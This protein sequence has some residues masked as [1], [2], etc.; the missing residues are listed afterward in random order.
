MVVS[1]LFQFRVDPGH[2]LQHEQLQ[3]K[4][5]LEAE[6]GNVYYASQGEENNIPMCDMLA[7][8]AY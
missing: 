5:K 3:R 4:E 2:G 1:I 8:R 7:H 6:H